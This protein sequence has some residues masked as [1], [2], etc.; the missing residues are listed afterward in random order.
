MHAGPLLEVC[1]LDSR[2]SLLGQESLHHLSLRDASHEVSEAEQGLHRRCS[3]LSNVLEDL[4]SNWLG[5]R[6]LSGLTQL[7]F[8][9][10]LE[11]GEILV[12]LSGRVVD[13][14]LRKMPIALAMRIAVENP[15]KGQ[16]LAVWVPSSEFQ[17]CGKDTY[18][19]PAKVSQPVSFEQGSK[20]CVLDLG[21]AALELLIANV[22]LVSFSSSHDSPSISSNRQSVG[23]PVFYDLSRLTVDYAWRILL[24]SVWGNRNSLFHASVAELAFYRAAGV[25]SPFVIP[26]N[27]DGDYRRRTL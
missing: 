21:I 14:R 23:K 8:K 17:P 7:G 12:E 10:D 16:L 22:F 20:L 1:V 15:N 2:V 19:I 18:F 13:L 25:V 5:V 26:F 3:A 27:G 24:L 9:L 6:L 11:T 4:S